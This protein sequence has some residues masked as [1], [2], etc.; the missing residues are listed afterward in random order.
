M[1]A[2][3]GI[4][5]LGAVRY[6]PVGAA[7]EPGFLLD[8]GD[9]HVLGDARVDRGLKADYCPRPEVLPHRAARPLHGA[10]VRRRVVV[11]GSGDG[12]D[13]EAGLGELLRV[14][15]EVDGR[16]ADCLAD[17]PGGVDPVPVLADALLVYVE[18]D[19]GNML[20]ELDGDGHAHVAEPDE[21]ELCLIRNEVGVYVVELHLCVFL[22]I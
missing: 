11:D 1:L 14:G 8:D 18:P 13:D 9:A 19:D 21:R 6:L 17:L 22:S 4:Y 7:L 20:G 16:P 12:H 5:P 15:G 10:Q 2:V 3:T